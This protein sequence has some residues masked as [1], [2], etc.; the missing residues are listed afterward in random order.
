ME[1]WRTAA[2]SYENDEQME[3]MVRMK[4]EMERSNW[5]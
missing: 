1:D 2:G 4:E 3:V 5:S